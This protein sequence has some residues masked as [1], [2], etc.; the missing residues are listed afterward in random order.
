MVSLFTPLFLRN[1]FLCNNN[2]L[3]LITFLSD[4]HRHEKFIGTIFIQTTKHTS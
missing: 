3:V 4:F 2:F 1:R